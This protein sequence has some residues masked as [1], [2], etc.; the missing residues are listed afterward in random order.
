M[1]YRLLQGEDKMNKTISLD[2]N[3]IDR[4][5]KRAEKLGFRT[6]SAYLTY[7]INKDCGEIAATKEKGGNNPSI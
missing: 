2:K 6:F 5:L 3:V 7:L 4:G 1:Y